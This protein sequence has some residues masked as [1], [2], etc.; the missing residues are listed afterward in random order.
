MVAWVVQLHLST[1]STNS[2][3]SNFGSQN[4]GQFGDPG[5]QAVPRSGCVPTSNS[6]APPLVVL[7]VASFPTSPTEPVSPL[8]VEV[9]RPELDPVLENVPS[10]PSPPPDD[11]APPSPPQPI[12]NRVKSP[13]VL[14][15]TPDD[16]ACAMR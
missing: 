13:A 16:T 14:L 15:T 12:A 10:V 2:S 11:S 1:G 8:P 4:S 3:A 9:M 6:G 7:V 5:V